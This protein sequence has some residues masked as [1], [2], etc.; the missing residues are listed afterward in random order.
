MGK[1]YRRP[2]GTFGS[3]ASAKKDKVMAHRCLRR[4]QE[5]S[6]RAA[7]DFEEYIIP[8]RYEAAHNDVWGWAR[9]GKQHFQDHPPTIHAWEDYEQEMKDHERW[10]A[11]LKRK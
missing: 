9:D 6:L 3:C 4:L 1:S 8:L 7:Q 2:Y 10:L 5:R 11:G